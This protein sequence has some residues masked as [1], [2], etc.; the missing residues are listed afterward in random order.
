ML[1]AV[2]ITKNEE[3]N[4]VRCLD[5]LKFCDEVI[6]VEDAKGSTLRVPLAAV[7]K[8]RLAFNWKR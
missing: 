5:S 2:V 8:A 4:I 3:K 6:V 7:T 1:A